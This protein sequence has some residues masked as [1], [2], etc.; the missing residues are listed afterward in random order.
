MLAYD[1]DLNCSANFSCTAYTQK[2]V[3]TWLLRPHVP[4]EHPIPDLVCLCCSNH[5]LSS[6]KAFH[7]ILE[8]AS[9]DF[10][11]SA[12][13]AFERS[14]TD[15]GWDDG[16]VV[17][18]AF[19]FIPEVCSGVEI[20]AR[21]NPLIFFHANLGKPDYKFKSRRCHSH[22]WL[23]SMGAKLALLLGWVVY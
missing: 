3:D 20:R 2:Y 7:L 1:Y 15:D 17:Q 9:G 13:G 14:G 11:H 10:V 22:P 12:P 19:R 23:G 4:V 5:R 16:L 21:G 18:S 6:G 8:H